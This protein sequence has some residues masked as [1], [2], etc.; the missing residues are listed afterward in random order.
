M[1]AGLV[2]EIGYTQL[3]SGSKKQQINLVLKDLR[4]LLL[5]INK[6]AKKFLERFS[7]EAFVCY[8]QDR[9]KHLSYHHV[10]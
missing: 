6:V 8:S 5:E 10:V 3:Q 2:S 9:K 7:L 1:L 4:K